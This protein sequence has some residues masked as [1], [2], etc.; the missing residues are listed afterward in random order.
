M[1]SMPGVLKSLKIWALCLIHSLIW[2]AAD[3]AVLRK[4]KNISEQFKFQKSEI[5]SFEQYIPGTF[6]YIPWIVN[7]SKVAEKANDIVFQSFI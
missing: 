4:S 6:K 7:D 5:F 3:E 2:G 1:E